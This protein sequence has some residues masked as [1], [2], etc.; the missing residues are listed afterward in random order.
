VHLPSH[1]PKPAQ[2][3]AKAPASTQ[4]TSGFV[5]NPFSELDVKLQQGA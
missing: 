3:P 2:S 4:P 1:E 5:H